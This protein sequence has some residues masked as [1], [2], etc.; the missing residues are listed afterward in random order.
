MPVRNA[1]AEWKGTLKEGNGDFKSESGAIGG[2]YS[3]GSRFGDS[4]G[5]NP[6]ELLAAAEAACFS[7]ALSGALEKN[8]ARPESIRTEAACTV[9]KVGDGFEITTIKLRVRARASGID[10]AKF[11]EV[12][13]GTKAGCPV[14]KALAGVDILLEA[15]LEA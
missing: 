9:E 3:F 6:E 15:T 8:G 12:A 10:N 5:T 7:M 13:E 1:S 2:S 11:Q 4:G 14:S